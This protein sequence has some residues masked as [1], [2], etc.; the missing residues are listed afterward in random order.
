[1]KAIAIFLLSCI[2]TISVLGQTAPNART[3]KADYSLFKKQIMELPEYL[4]EKQAASKLA[5]QAGMPVKI[6][7]TITADS[8]DD[9]DET[10][11]NT[12]NG[13]IQEE[14]GTD[15]E[16]VYEIQFDRVA[17]KITSVQHVADNTESEEDDSDKP[18]HKKSKKSDGD[19]EE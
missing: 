3:R 14:K 5:K 9:N 12:L 15:R 10:S 18:T 7:I 11:A 16:T 8:A 13:Y 2:C 4:Q 17:Q 19:D 1:M 6:V